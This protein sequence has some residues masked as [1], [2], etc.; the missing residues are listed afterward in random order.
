MPADRD[1]AHLRRADRLRR[2]RVGDRHE[3]ERRRRGRAPGRATCRK[4]A[5]V[6]PGTAETL[7]RHGIEPAFVAAVSTADGLVAEFPQPDGPR[8]LPRGRELA[9]RADRRARRRLRPALPHRSCSQPE[10]PE[11]DVVVLASGSAA[12]AY[13]WIGGRRAGDLDRPG[14]LARSR[15]RSAST[16]PSRRRRTTSTASSRRSRSSRA[17][18]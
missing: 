9:P 14:D 15:A 12:R 13:A 8:D 11:G 1:R 4:V 18:S 10:P 3:P 16:S 2:L 6:G 7:R 5:A 17:G